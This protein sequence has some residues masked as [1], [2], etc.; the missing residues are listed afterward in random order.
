VCSSDLIVVFEKKNFQE[1]KNTWERY[2]AFFLL[3]LSSVIILFH[4]HYWL[5]T[6][7]LSRARARS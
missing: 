5:L 7:V 1:N 6:I 3:A 4:Y 2:P